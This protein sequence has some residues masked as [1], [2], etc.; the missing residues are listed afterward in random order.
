VIPVLREARRK[1]LADIFLCTA[2]DFSFAGMERGAKQ[3]AGRR[4][5]AQR[6]FKFT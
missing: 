4:C 3:S 6:A 2:V 1:N 5:R